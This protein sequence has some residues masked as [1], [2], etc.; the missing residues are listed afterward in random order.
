[1][2]A[3]GPHPERHRERP[4]GGAR[5]LVVDAGERARDAVRQ[6]GDGRRR[7]EGACDARNAKAPAKGAGAYHAGDL[8]VVIASP[9]LALAALRAVARDDAITVRVER[10][11]NSTLNSDNRNGAPR[12]RGIAR[13]MAYRRPDTLASASMS[14]VSNSPAFASRFR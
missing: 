3:A 10:R 7:A 6:S 12:L 8:L 5:R 1:R 4:A 11:N 14:V 9:R 2:C 13:G